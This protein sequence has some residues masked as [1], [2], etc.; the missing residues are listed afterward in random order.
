MARVSR[1]KR[2]A[3]TRLQVCSGIEPFSQKESSGSDDVWPRVL[4]SSEGGDG[5][6]QAVGAKRLDVVAAIER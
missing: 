3:I 6:A 1:S 2:R 5:L 4:A